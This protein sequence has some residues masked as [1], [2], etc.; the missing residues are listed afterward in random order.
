M[1]KNYF[2]L[3]CSLLLG[4]AIQAQV[5]YTGNGNSGF[6]GTVGGS[7]LNIS[8]DGTTMTFSF[9]RGGSNL[10]NVLVIYVDSK[11][12]GF[13]NTNSFNDTGGADRIAISTTN[14]SD[15]DPEVSFPSGFTADYAITAKNDFAGIF[16]LQAT[17]SHTFIASADLT[18]NNDASSATHTFT[19]D[20]SEIGITNTDKFDFVVTYCSGDSWLSNEVIGDTSNITVGT[21]AGVNPGPDGSI[22]FSDSRSYP[23]TW[24]GA[25]DNDWATGTNWTEGVPTSTHNVHIPSGLTNYPTA[26]AA[27]TINKGTVESGAS[28]IA[29]DA[30][31]GTITYE[32]SLGTAN[33]YL[34]SSPVVGEDATDFLTNSSGISNNGSANAIGTYSDGWTYNYSSTLESG[35]G[36]AVKKDAPGNLVFTGTFQSSSVAKLILDTTSDF[37]LFGNPY[38]SYIAANSNADGINNLLTVNTASGQDELAEATIW[39]WNQGTDSYDQVNQASGSFHIAPGQ[40]FFIKGKSGSGDTFFDFTEAMQSH[41]SSDSFQ[42]SASTRPEVKLMLTDGTMNRDADIYY[43]DGKTTGFDNGYDSSI[44]GGINHDFT[45]YTEAVANSD[46]KRLG[47]QSLPNQD[48]ESMVIPVGVIAA[49]GKEITFTAEALN[50]P[51]GI[52]VYLED[53][54]ANNVT[55]LD[56]VNSNYKVTLNTALNGTGRFFLHTRSS[57][58]STEEVALTGVGMYTI[59]KNTLRVNGIN[60]DK[61]SIKI[62]NILGKKVLDNSFTSKGVSDV[63]LPNLNTGVYIVQ[64]VTEKGKISKKII[65]E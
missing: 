16:E 19:V 47:I 54:E 26:S 48:F 27:V 17:G 23:N 33:W 7:T 24:T 31:T 63:S 30:F 61:A 4:V 1:K 36:Y 12:G 52:K 38:T 14:N 50:L 18:P 15:R 28:L 20:F 51:S 10:D 3:L 32:R 57:A 41:Q 46:G 60:S 43:I 49:S 21:G 11:T 22:T 9:S 55:R 13:S 29:Q 2:L 64:L 5:S 58:L 40:G 37:N 8:D 45:V 44:F 62:Y 25:T 53:R 59:N 34:I 39:L 65:L 6:G 42:K 56:E 35:A